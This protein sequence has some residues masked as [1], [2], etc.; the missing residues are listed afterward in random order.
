MIFGFSKLLRRSNGQTFRDKKGASKENEPRISSSD[1]FHDDSSRLAT[2][3]QKNNRRNCQSRRPAYTLNKTGHRADEL[4]K[5]AHKSDSSEVLF[6]F[7]FVLGLDLFLTKD[8]LGPQKIPG[9]LFWKTWITSFVMSV[10][11]KQLSTAP[12]IAMNV[13]KRG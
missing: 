1:D 12:L 6:L 7:F 11:M 5:L 3:Q 10:L 13:P 9:V 2:E 4:G 8:L